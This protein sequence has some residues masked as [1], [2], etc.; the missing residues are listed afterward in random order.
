MWTTE[1]SGMNIFVPFPENL[2]F[3]R[4]CSHHDDLFLGTDPVLNE[5]RLAGV[6]L[7]RLSPRRNAFPQY[8]IQKNRIDILAI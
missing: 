3:L 7:F 1:L 8:Y 4:T 5:L 2:Q 6:S